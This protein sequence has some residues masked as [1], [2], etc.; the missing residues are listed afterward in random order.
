MQTYLH[1]HLALKE[2]A[3]AKVTPYQGGNQTMPNGMDTT[4]M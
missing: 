2:A 1:A 4:V 3:L